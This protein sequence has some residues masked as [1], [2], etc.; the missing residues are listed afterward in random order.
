MLDLRKANVVGGKNASDLQA[1]STRFQSPRTSIRI[2]L[3]IRTFGMRTAISEQIAGAVGAA[4]VDQN[5]LMSIPI[6]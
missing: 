6:C 1:I 2:V 4:V 3:D 5:D